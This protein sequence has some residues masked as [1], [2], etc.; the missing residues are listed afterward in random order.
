MIEVSFWC[1]N[2]RT[3][4]A[5]N[6]L[7]TLL[8]RFNDAVIK[9]TIKFV[10]VA[11]KFVNVAIKFVKILSSACPN[12]EFDHC[13]YD[14][15][16]VRVHIAFS[17]FFTNVKKYIFDI[18]RDWFSWHQDLIFSCHLVSYPDTDPGG[19]LGMRLVFIRT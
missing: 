3:C 7:Q 13:Y 17:G 16:V 19:R 4:T 12:I 6:C 1:L 11:I 2:I 9:I 18:S 8:Q 5:Q 15:Q 14:L 10:N